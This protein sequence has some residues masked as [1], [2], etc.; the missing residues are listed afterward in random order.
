MV[1]FPAPSVDRDGAVPSH[2]AVLTVANLMTQL[3]AHMWFQLET[4]MKLVTIGSRG[5]L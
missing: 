2:M 3:E 1:Q 5:S 4:G